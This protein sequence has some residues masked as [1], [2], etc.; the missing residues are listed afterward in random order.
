MPKSDDSEGD[1]NPRT[2]IDRAF[3]TNDPKRTE[4]ILVRHGQQN[5][6]DIDAAIEDWRDPPLTDLGERQAHAAGE[7]LAN[8]N[9]AAVYS[10][11][12]QRA[13]RTGIA[14][15]ERHGLDVE[16]MESLAEIHMFGELEPHQ[17]PIDVMTERELNGAR[18]RFALQRR[19][20]AYPHTESSIDFRR[21]TANAIEGII[22]HHPAETVVVACH[23]GVI[24]AYLADFLG[25]HADMF[26]R[27]AHASIHRVLARHDR[28]VVLSLNEMHHLRGPADLLTF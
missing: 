18:H 17:R 5:F 24:N 26:Y 9:I 7:S 12:L 19:W 16:V 2:P 23:G 27:P 3:I 10:S 22:A 14:V 4:L 20:E 8:D 13:H 11:Q 15:A 25:L 28:R 1:D 21:R 6:P